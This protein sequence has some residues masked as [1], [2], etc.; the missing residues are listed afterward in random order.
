MARVLLADDNESVLFLLNEVVS[1]LGHEVVAC[2]RDGAQAKEA[3]MSCLPDIVIMDY[4]MPKLNGIQ[5]AKWMMQNN[6]SMT[7]III[8]SGDIE[9]EI[10]RPIREYYEREYHCYRKNK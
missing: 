4:N 2:C 9:A 5:V 3:Y 8:C 6:E 10:I 1:F 7:K